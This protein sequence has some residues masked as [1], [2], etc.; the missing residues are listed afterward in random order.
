[1][2]QLTALNKT[3]GWESRVLCVISLIYVLAFL[4]ILCLLPPFWSLMDEP[5]T[6]RDVRAAFSTQNWWT[7]MM[8]G[9]KGDFGWGMFRPVLFIVDYFFYGYLGDSSRL[10]YLVNFGV[11]ILMLWSWSVLFGQMAHDSLPNKLPQDK[12]NWHYLFFI[13]CCLFTP[14]YNL[15]YYPTAQDKYTLLFGLL[16]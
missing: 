3:N 16:V 8:E 15:F 5:G 4:A 12:N 10:A 14:H 11:M 7:Y 13:L 2:I 9:V 6:L 1:M